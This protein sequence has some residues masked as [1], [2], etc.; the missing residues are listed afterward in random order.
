MS[1][2]KEHVGEP[3]PRR[4][5][6]GR[7]IAVAAFLSGSAAGCFERYCQSG[8]IGT[9]CHSQN[10][11]EWQETQIRTDGETPKSSLDIAPGCEVSMPGGT[12]Y[13]Q[14]LPTGTNQGPP[15]SPFNK[16]GLYRYSHACVN[17]RVPA[18][19]ALR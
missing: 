3:T 15:P 2:S 8:A 6:R 18:H 14:P 17:T 19:G 10:A 13:Q 7:W 4:G 11:I 16:P 9:H 1:R 5:A 12:T